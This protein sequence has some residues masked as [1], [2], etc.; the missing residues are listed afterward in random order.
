MIPAR[1][2]L[3]VAALVLLGGA[4]LHL[5]LTPSGAD[6]DE[7]AFPTSPFC[8]ASA[9]PPRVAWCVAGGARTLSEPVVHRSI[10]TNLIDAFGA[11]STVFALLKTADNSDKLGWNVP[12]RDSSEAEVAAALAVLGVSRPNLRFATPAEEPVPNPKCQLL[13]EWMGKAGKRQGVKTWLNSHLPGTLGQISSWSQCFALVKEHER[14]TGVK[15]DLVAKVRPDTYWFVVR[16][17]LILYP[18]VMILYCTMT[19]FKNGEHCET[20]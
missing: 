9:T 15:F 1:R 19:I 12:A 5:L 10:R 3:G 2:L 18:K 14:E 16:V 7:A 4:C 17:T 6:T 13:P 11:R 8:A 20:S